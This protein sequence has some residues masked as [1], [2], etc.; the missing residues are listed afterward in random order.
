MTLPKEFGD[1]VDCPVSTVRA[2]SIA[3]GELP[4]SGASVKN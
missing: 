3:R 1:C 4:A 2:R